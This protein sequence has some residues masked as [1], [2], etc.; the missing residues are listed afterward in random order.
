MHKNA[1]M[2]G[3]TGVAVLVVAISGC[4]GTQSS[5]SGSTSSA[6]GSASA[7]GPTR[8]IVDGTDQK[9]T[10]PVTCTPSGDN[11][12]ISVGDATAGIGAVVS[13]ATPPVV[14]SVGLGTVNGVTL[15][16]ADAA[17]GDG[18]ASATKTGN[19]YQIT[20]TAVGMDSANGQQ[21]KTSTFELDLNCP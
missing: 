14:H 5:K 3:A 21:Q 9:V 17:P 1:M 2:L 20:G 10:G 19:S 4:S 7:A 8:V 11:T 6:P 18:N 16:F 12:N 15:G 13:N